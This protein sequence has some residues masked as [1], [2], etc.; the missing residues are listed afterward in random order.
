MSTTSESLV[1]PTPAVSGFKSILGNKDTIRIVVEIVTL[2]SICYYF[3]SKYSNTLKHIEDLSQRIEDQDD[4]LE[5]NS[6]TLSGLMENIDAINSHLIGLERDKQTRPPM[7]PTRF[8]PPPQQRPPQQPTLFE[9]PPQQR[10]PPQQQRPP[11]QKTLFEPPPQQRPPTQKNQS[12][13]SLLTHSKIPKMDISNRSDVK[14]TDTTSIE[15][16][17]HT[18][19]SNIDAQLKKEID[20]L[21]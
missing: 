16:L 3:N 15:I 11:M 10:P 13:E 5:K 7:Q 8:E 21:A 20:D 18:D 17:D 12:E 2:L 19:P 14:P 9:P 1:T 4:I 6:K